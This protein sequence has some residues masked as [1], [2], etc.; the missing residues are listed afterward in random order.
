M[1]LL[2]LE[3]LV[4]LSCPSQ[5]AMINNSPAIMASVSTYFIGYSAKLI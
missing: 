5:H 2:V 4:I 1:T 3:V